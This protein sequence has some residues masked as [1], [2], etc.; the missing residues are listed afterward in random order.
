MHSQHGVFFSVRFK[1]KTKQI[2]KKLH[3][4]C[5]LIF[6]NNYKCDN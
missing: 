5:I 2:I 1:V 3:A 4:T 6:N